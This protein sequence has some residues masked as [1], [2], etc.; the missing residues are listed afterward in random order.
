MSS[1]GEE[2][3]VVVDKSLALLESGVLNETDGK[4]IGAGKSIDEQPALTNTTEGH[5]SLSPNLK[6]LDTSAQ[7]E[8]FNFSSYFH[9][10]F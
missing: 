3:F 6:N 1:A 7:S 2:S 10:T 8:V 4:E 9:L 5:V